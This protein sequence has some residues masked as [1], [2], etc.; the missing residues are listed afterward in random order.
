MKKISPWFGHIYILVV[1]SLFCAYQQG[2]AAENTNADAELGQPYF[3]ATAEGELVDALPLLLTTVDINIVGFIADVTVIQQYK[4]DGDVPLEATY[5]FPG[6]E[7]AAVYDMQMEIGERVIRS[8][9]QEK[10]KAKQTYE[11]AISEGKTASLLQ[12]ASSNYFSTSVGNILPGD[13][14]Q[15]TLKYTESLIANDGLYT[16]HFPAKSVADAKSK[17]KSKRVSENIGFDVTATVRAAFPIAAIESPSHPINVEWYKN[18]AAITLHEDAFFSGNDDFVLNYR[19][20]GDKIQSGLLLYEGEEENYFLLMAQPPEKVTTDDIPAREYRFIVDVSGSMTGF[21]LAL[22]KDVSSEIMLR[23]RPNDRFNLHTFAT[24]NQKFSPEPVEA[25]EDALVEALTMLEVSTAGGGTDLLPVLEEIA[26]EP[27]DPGVS[28]ILIVI[29]DGVIQADNDLLHFVRTH[30]NEMNVFTIGVGGTQYYNARVIEGLAKAGHGKSFQLRSHDNNEKKE[31]LL[32]HFLDYVGEP[33]LSDINLSMPTEF[34]TYDVIP[35]SIPDVFSERPVYVVG[36]WK[37]RPAGNMILNGYTGA[38]PYQNRFAI[39]GAPNTPKNEAIRLLWAHEKIN[40]LEWNEEAAGL[41]S[42]EKDSI[43][44]IA[45]KHNLLSKYT[46][47]VSVDSEVRTDSA[48]T[49][50]NVRL[51]RNRKVETQARTPVRAPVSGVGLSTGPIALAIHQPEQRQQALARI[52]Y[53]ETFPLPADPHREMVTFILG[54]DKDESNPYFESASM[55]FDANAKKDTG[56]R[57][58]TH[59]RD[60]SAVKTWLQQN[61]PEEYPWGIINIVSHATPWTGADLVSLLPDQDMDAKHSN[62]NIDQ[63]TQLRVYS[64]GLGLLPEQLDSI[65]RY[66]S[67]VEHQALA[68]SSPMT[69]IMFT[70]SE[71]AD[72]ISGYRTLDHWWVV[73]NTRKALTRK[74]LVR[75]LTREHGE[76]D[77]EV[78]LS[79]ELAQGI[80]ALNIEPVKIRMRLEGDVNYRRINPLVMAKRQEALKKT[81]AATSIP[82][83]NLRW[84]FEKEG[85][86]NYLVGQGWLHQVI[87]RPAQNSNKSVY[88]YLKAY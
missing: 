16:F 9:V 65:A 12:Q 86:D 82:I 37:G 26:K 50:N 77:W 7:N 20:S 38:S 55:Y 67:P 30:L 88:A 51:Q 25:S 39:H 49:I 85:D 35:Q 31:E 74:A 54:E 8:I 73:S 43:T 63:Y 36:K 78:L 32:A 61:S 64:C 10:N 46:S 18:S 84:T 81:L 44:S 72:Q 42:T 70:G 80:S 56:A 58:I 22:A 19:L 59:L 3:R 57:V 1:L 23:L 2:I 79:Q 45:L 40:Q 6:S 29:T 48:Q 13:D 33:V 87:S 5:I 76:R 68:I 17:N 28:R 21:P 4:N 83:E 15:V 14:I 53:R 71:V 47:F 41:P 34:Q 11:K 75:Q 52:E 24:A 69:P 62:K 27:Q 66:L 60:L